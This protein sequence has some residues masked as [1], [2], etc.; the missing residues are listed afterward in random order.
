MPR[1]TFASPAKATLAPFLARQSRN[2]IQFS[3][4]QSNVIFLLY[5]PRQAPA[6]RRNRT[7]DK[8]NGSNP[9]RVFFFP[10]CFYAFFF[11]LS[12]FFFFSSFN[13]RII[14]LLTLNLSVCAPDCHP[15]ATLNT[16]V[17]KKK[18][19]PSPNQHPFS[20]HVTV[21]SSCAPSA[22]RLPSHPVA[23]LESCLM[24]PRF[25]GSTYPGS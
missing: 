15:G 5:Y 22:I 24:A 9:G 6:S 21:C 25:R 8:V 13:L 23:I 10:F 4:S 17:G 19:T 14:L 20:S 3:F 16:V 7:H 18:K 2:N 11:S 1:A 12:F